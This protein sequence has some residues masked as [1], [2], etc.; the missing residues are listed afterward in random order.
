MKTIEDSGF[1][2]APAAS[3][4]TSTV[5]TFPFGGAI[6]DE[7]NSPAKTSVDHS[8]RSEVSVQKDAAREKLK[9]YYESLK[10]K[11][12]GKLDREKLKSDKSDRA[13]YLREKSPTGKYDRD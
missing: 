5:P 11:K 2:K 12:N 13:K 9:A 10:A 6:S 3:A 4:V 1:V 7:A 8:R